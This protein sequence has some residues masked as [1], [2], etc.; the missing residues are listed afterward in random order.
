MNGL[1]N[2]LRQSIAARA[3]KARNAAGPMPP[4]SLFCP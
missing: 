1:R 3:G 2:P 4:T